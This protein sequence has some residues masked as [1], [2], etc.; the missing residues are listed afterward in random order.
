MD[1]IIKKQIEKAN[2]V[3]GL[4][5]LINKRGEVLKAHAKIFNTLSIN[6][7]AGEEKTQQSIFGLSVGMYIW[8]LHVACV[9]N[10]VDLIG[11]K[12]FEKEFYNPLIEGAY[13]ATQAEIEYS[14]ALVFEKV[15]RSPAR[16]SVLAMF[17]EL[18]WSVWNHEIAHVVSGHTRIVCEDGTKR[19]LR[20]LGNIDD[21]ALFLSVSDLKIIEADADCNA[22]SMRT[23]EILNLMANR[24]HEVENLTRKLA[25]FLSSCIT[26]F[27]IIFKTKGG[28][29]VSETN[30]PSPLSRLTYTFQMVKL[31]LQVNDIDPEIAD[32]ALEEALFEYRKFEAAVPDLS[33]IREIQEDNMRGGLKNEVWDIGSQS[34]ARR[35]YFGNFSFGSTVLDIIPNPFD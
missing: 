25:R 5:N 21:I 12:I 24:L 17:L 23:A 33:L 10:S 14:L 29:L 2:R 34:I 15:S 20:E 4:Y 35:D 26:F 22:A 11:I 19:F 32:R 16:K 3:V 8:I 9:L 31:T 6:G 30:Y 28:R 7:Y 27:A 18:T 1:L 13:S